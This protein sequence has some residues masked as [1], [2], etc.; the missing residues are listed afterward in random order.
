LHNFHR[1]SPVMTFV[2][3]SARFVSP[4]SLPTCMIPAATAS[5]TAW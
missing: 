4:S 1:L 3:R 2:N 5:H